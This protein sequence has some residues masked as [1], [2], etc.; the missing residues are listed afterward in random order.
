MATAHRDSELIA[1]LQRENAGLKQELAE[2]LAR[3][4]QLLARIEVL[5][6]TVARQAGPFRRGEDQKV[7]ADKKKRPGRKKGH[8]GARRKRPSYVSAEVNVPL[9]ACPHCQG[10][11]EDRTPIT[12]FIEEIPQ[13][14]P[15]V[16]RLTTW[17]AK[18]AACGKVHSSHPLQTS[19]AIGAAEV[20]LGPRAAAFAILLN[21]QLGLPLR[22]TCQVLK[23]AFGL[24]LTSGGLVQLEHRVANKLRPAYA[25]LQD[26]IRT[27]AAVYADETSWYVGDPHNWLWVFTTPQG[28]LYHV[29][30]SR[31]GPVAEKILGADF[32][33]VL[34]TDCFSGYLRFKGPQHKCIF[35][36]L[37]ALKRARNQNRTRRSSYLDAWESL[38][39]DV[40]D[41][42]RARDELPAESFVSSRAQLEARYDDLLAQR[43][44]QLGDRK[45]QTRMTKVGAHRFG[46]LYYPVDATSNR[47]ERA[48]RPAVIARKI[49]CGNR[50]D[51]GAATWQILVSLAT[52]AYQ[53]GRDFVRELANAIVFEPVLAR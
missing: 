14:Q 8:R 19:Q 17:Q 30:S 4:E 50:T 34:V 18:C 31:G 49:S 27:S 47:A 39:Q 33:G 11:V 23:E 3:I 13:L 9:E 53:T 38:W 45:F 5:E 48:I 7:P 6:R 29:D 46:C 21:K 36:H 22:K 16:T 12:Q 15:V 41:L 42:H 24:S 44:T 52:T 32:G 35:H 26:E 2:A 40:L 20:Q 1:E 43:L 37:Q 28:T 51:R 25:A 10:P